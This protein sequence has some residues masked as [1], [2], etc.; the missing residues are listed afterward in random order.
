MRILLTNDDGIMAPGLLAMYQELSKMGEVTIV[1][2]AT[3]QSAVGH[4]I[5]VSIPLFSQRID[6]GGIGVTG[7]SVDG[8]P[9]D[10]VKMAILEILKDSRPDLV[11]S[12]INNGENV[13]INILYSGTVAAAIEG[14]FFGV[15]SVAVSLAFAER[16]EFGRAARV[17][18]GLIEQFLTNGH[19]DKPVLLNLNIPDL[20][21]RPEPRG[22]RLCRMAV[23]SGAERLIRRADPRG[24]PYFWMTESPRKLRDLQPESDEL[25]LAEGYVTLTPLQ[26]DMSDLRSLDEMQ[27]WQLSLPGEEPVT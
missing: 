11:V 13:G 23:V 10:C 12:G 24:R 14:A 17:A 25:A 6:V 2:P 8:R 16:M 18:R 9:A 5:S 26:F 3:A 1:A 20:A 7:H 22:V 4:A 27:K 21:V 19:G 15:P